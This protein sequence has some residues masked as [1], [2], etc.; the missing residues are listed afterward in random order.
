L[1][2]PCLLRVL[3][4]YPLWS[5]GQ[6]GWLGVAKLAMGWPLQLAALAAMVWVLNRDDTPVPAT[7]TA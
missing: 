2:A 7:A 4:Q 6:A 3:V 1:A 5:T